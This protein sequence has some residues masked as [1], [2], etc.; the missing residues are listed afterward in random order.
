M[1]IFCTVKFVS[2][3]CVYCVLP[4]FAMGCGSSN[5]VAPSTVIEPRPRPARNA[6]RPL[7]IHLQLTSE[8]LPMPALI[9]KTPPPTSAQVA[10]E[11]PKIKG[12]ISPNASKRQSQTLESSGLKFE[13]TGGITVN[14]VKPPLIHLAPPP[15]SKQGIIYVFLNI[16]Q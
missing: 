6:I 14:V 12:Q 15:S 3:F 10:Q 1:S 11:L 16:S 5:T 8:P 4:L 2:I 13:N 7:P 9:A